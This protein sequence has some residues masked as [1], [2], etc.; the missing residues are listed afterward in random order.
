M[1][2]L[3]V[4]Q[5]KYLESGI[6]IG[7]KMK[8]AAMNPFIYRKRN[9]GLY[10]LD[11]RKVDE[12]LR[13]A[14]E[15]V[16]KHD[17]A[18]MLVV[19][20]RIYSGYAA[21]KFAKFLGC[22]VILGR[23]IPGTLTNVSRPYFI[24][25]K[26]L[27]VC[28]PKA[29]KQAIVEAVQMSI[30]VCGLCD[31][32]NFTGGVTSIIPCNNKGRRSLALVFYLL[33]REYHMKRNLISSYDEFKLTS[34]D[35]ESDDAYLSL[36]GGVKEVDSEEDAEQASESQDAQGKSK[37]EEGAPAADVQAE[38]KKPRKRKTAH[39]KEEGEEKKPGEAAE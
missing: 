6:H 39:K 15:E 9:D 13:A 28:D 34:E 5:E 27:L 35:F 32:D 26:F 10:V 11:L 20:S 38:H 17:P 33:A 29:E 2:S 16:A 21:A 25:P 7:T 31:T 23:F 22:K 18:D 1:E 24:E 4:K 8:V 14:A 12:S 37:E 19:A 3:L 30:P 36:M